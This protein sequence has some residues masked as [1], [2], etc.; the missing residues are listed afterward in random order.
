MGIREIPLNNTIWNP[1]EYL[2]QPGGNFTHVTI[3]YDI[4]GQRNKIDDHLERVIA[5]D[6]ALQKIQCVNTTIYWQALFGSLNDTSALLLED[7][8]E[9]LKILLTSL[10]VNSSA[11]SGEKVT[12]YCMVGN[13]RAF[14]FEL[15]A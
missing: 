8:R 15:D 12:A 7:V 4:T 1:G 5:E 9:Q 3:S 6:D 14:A 13:I 11:L 10:F 2:N